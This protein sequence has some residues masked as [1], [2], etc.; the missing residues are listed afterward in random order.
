MA[1]VVRLKRYHRDLEEWRR[2]LKIGSE[3][4]LRVPL[5]DGPEETSGVYHPYL[6]RYRKEAAYWYRVRVIDTKQTGNFEREIKLE[7]GQ[8]RDLYVSKSGLKESATFIG[9]YASPKSDFP[10]WVPIGNPALYQSKASVVPLKRYR[11]DLE[12]WRRDLKI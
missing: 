10:E 9:T 3:I 4:F 7:Y 6:E 12:E 2:N 1:A 8:K 5:Y 11:R